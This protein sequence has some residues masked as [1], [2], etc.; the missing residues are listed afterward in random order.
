MKTRATL[1]IGALLALLV[2]A[3]AA[4][5]RT[6]PPPHSTTSAAHELP[7]FKFPLGAQPPHVYSGGTAKQVTV[8]DFP[9]SKSIAGV[10]MT[11]EPGALRELHWHANAAEW[12]Y[13]FEG[14]VRVTVTDPEGRTEI[15]DFAPGDV[16]YFPRGH[17][18]S[19]EGVGPGTAK[20]LLV[21]D[22]GA[23]SEF[24][25]FS[26]SDWIA[27]TPK[28][29]VAK[30]LGLSVDEVGGFPTKEVYIAKGPIPTPLDRTKA[31]GGA[32]PS[33]PLTH[34]FSLRAQ[35][36]V[37]DGQA[38]EVW[39]A[40]QREFPISTAMTG[41]FMHLQ[42]GGLREMHWHPNADEWQYVSKGHLR[43][44]VFASSG[45]ASVT[46]LGPGDVGFVPMGYGHALESV[47]D[48]PAEAIL[49]LNSGNYE[50]ISLSGLLAAQPRY[51]LGTNFKVPASVIDRLPRAEKFFAG[52]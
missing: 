46:E 14:T 9:V 28:E 8:A 4:L 32:Q 34:K 13:I 51:L 35:R 44:T 36:P 29:I 1:M 52:P 18:H 12:A 3:W 21:F 48:E 19:L 26:V 17:A 20:F 47:G 45:L 38:G 43:L 39:L 25:T 11:L 41:L 15:A 10:F 23:F 31:L 22:N 42:P 24:A 50:E 6:R 33:P 16:W 27:H 37:K 30:N 2:V 5:A 7:S 40:S 49:M